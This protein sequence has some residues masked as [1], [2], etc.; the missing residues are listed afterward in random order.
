M[1]AKIILLA[2]VVFGLAMV[3]MNAQSVEATAAAAAHAGYVLPA[4]VMRDGMYMQVN[5]SGISA[6]GLLVDITVYDTQDTARQRRF[7]GTNAMGYASVRIDNMAVTSSAGVRVCSM[8]GEAQHV[9]AEASTY[10][11]IHEAV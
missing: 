7:F 11:S 8:A 2:I 6:S 1:R 4:L 10:F 9:C 3:C 5:W